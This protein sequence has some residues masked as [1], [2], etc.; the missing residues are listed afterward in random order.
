[1][2]LAAVKPLAVFG[3]LLAALVLALSDT[4]TVAA[5]TTVGV[6]ISAICGVISV[7]LTHNGNRKLN[8]ADRNLERVR[9]EVSDVKRHVGA[10][11]RHEDGDGNGSVTT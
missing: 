4:V 11:R 10:S 7:V 1:M 9:T 3:A 5:I 6:V 2:I 8:R